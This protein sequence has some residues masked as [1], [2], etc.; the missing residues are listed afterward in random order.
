M[1]V[2]LRVPALRFDRPVDKRHPRFDP[3]TDIDLVDAINAAIDSAAPEWTRE[4]IFIGAP[5]QLI[6]LAR[7]PAELRAVYLNGLRQGDGFYL[8]QGRALIFA[9]EYVLPGDTVEA[10]YR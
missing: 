8:L 2:R 6:Q 4:A 9:D 7:V 5:G 10:E 1:S 3:E